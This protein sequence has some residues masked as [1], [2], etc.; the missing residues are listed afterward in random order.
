MC[1]RHHYH[2]TLLPRLRYGA[3]PGGGRG[4]GGPCL[5]LLEEGNG[6]GGGEEVRRRTTCALVALLRLQE[7]RVLTFHG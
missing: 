5:P 3:F 7:S 1:H 6:R 2:H 4:S